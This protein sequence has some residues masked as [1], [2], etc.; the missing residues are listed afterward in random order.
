MSRKRALN[1]KYC[2]QPS[3]TEGHK[4]I[5]NHLKNSV[6]KR[7]KGDN[8]KNQNFFKKVLDKTIER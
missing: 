7:Q 6:K 4:V 5:K 2:R 1:R 3:F 8:K